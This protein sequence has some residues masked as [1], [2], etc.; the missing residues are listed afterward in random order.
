MLFLW[1]FSHCY[2]TNI[3]K[4][5]T[6]T[7]KIQKINILSLKSLVFGFYSWEIWINLDPQI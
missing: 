1:A 4:E 7:L 3:K 6:G 5:E 2:D